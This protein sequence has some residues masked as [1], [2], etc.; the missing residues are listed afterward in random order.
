MMPEW[1]T[2]PAEDRTAPLPMA[3]HAAKQ[4]G[5]QLGEEAPGA[6]FTLV[7]EQGAICVDGVCQIPE[8]LTD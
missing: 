5:E 3:D 7:G 4:P 2:V 8:A 6:P 1:P